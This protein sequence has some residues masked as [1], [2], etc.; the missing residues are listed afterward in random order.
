MCKMRGYI[1]IIYLY[2]SMLKYIFN[3]YSTMYC[4]ILYE[5]YIFGI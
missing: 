4:I 1:K 5:T 3:S 2:I